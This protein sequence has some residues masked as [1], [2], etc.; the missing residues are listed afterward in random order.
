[1]PCYT[2]QLTTVEFKAKHSDIL[3]QALKALKL[4]Y[5]F[6]NN[7]ISIIGSYLAIDLAK[8]QVRMERTET[9]LVNRIKQEYSKQAIL[10][11]SAK[12]K[13]IVKQLAD[14]KLALRRF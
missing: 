1:M 11:A 6:L 10:V 2:V 7:Q 3:E 8:Q 9:S 14:N 4:P 5:S 12:N 13:W